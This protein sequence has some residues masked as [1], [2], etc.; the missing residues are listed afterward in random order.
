MRAVVEAYEEAGFYSPGHAQFIPT[1]GESNLLHRVATALAALR[2]V[3]W[4]LLTRRVSLLHLHMS[5][6]GSFWRKAIFL[7]I[8]RLASV[9][10]IIHLHGS[11]FAVFFDR[12]SPLVKRIIVGIFDRASAVIVLS[13]SWRQF[14]GR[15]TKTPVTVIGNF[16][17]DHFDT[18]LAAETRGRRA[19]LFLGQFGERKGI[20]DLLP[21][22]A[23][24]RRR[25][26]GAMLYCGGNGDVEKVRATVRELGLEHA[27]RAPGWISGDEKLAL[28]HSCSVFVLPS[29]DENLPMAIIEAMSF[30]MAIVST[31]VGGIP[32][33]VDAGNGTLVAPGDRAQLADALVALLQKDAAELARLGTESRRRYETEFSPRIATLRMRE[34]YQSLGVEP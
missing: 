19:V 3:T 18:K 22:F 31:T 16:V 15:L 21:A 2:R 23:E 33:L 17:L 8:G 25:V 32:E 10:V 20:Y 27:V 1:H 4:L 12:S 7:L 5:M 28:L 26:E 13:D 6:R 14:I 9:P 11:E 24:V 29:H 34:L 30:S